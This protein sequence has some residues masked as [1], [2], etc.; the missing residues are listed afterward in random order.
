MRVRP[1][2]PTDLPCLETCDHHV[3]RAELQNL[4]RLGR[5]LIAEENGLFLGWLR[6]NLFWDSIPFMNMLCILEPHQGK[7]YGKAL[8]RYW[9]E[10]MGRAGH[11][12]VM[13]S[14]VSRE[15][16]QHF[17]HRLGYGTIGGF[18]LGDEPYEVILSKKLE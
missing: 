18:L 17:Y 10:Q 6:Y 4:I 9:E 1:A 11:T 5:V 12:V 14:T 16:A 15:Y 13:T 3:S 2:V 8:V 7:G